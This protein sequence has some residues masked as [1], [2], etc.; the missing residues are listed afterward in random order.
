MDISSIIKHVEAILAKVEEFEQRLAEL[1]KVVAPAAPAPE[2]PQVSD[3]GSV[4]QAGAH[5]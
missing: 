3:G 2:Q 4:P 1:E 5:E